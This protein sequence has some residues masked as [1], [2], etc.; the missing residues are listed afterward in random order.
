[1][2]EKENRNLEIYLEGVR[3]TSLVTIIRII[4]DIAS[5]AIIN[6]SRYSNKE[7]EV[8]YKTLVGTC[9]SLV[10]KSFMDESLRGNSLWMIDLFTKLSEDNTDISDL[11]DALRSK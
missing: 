5:Q 1:M 3:Q 9:I 6:D 4:R 2:T 10:V 8:I 11:M 7:K